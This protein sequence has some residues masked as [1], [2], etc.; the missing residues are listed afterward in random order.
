M[1]QNGRA[2]SASDYGY[3]FEVAGDNFSID[4]HFP[5]YMASETSIEEELYTWTTP[6][7][8]GYNDYVEFTTRNFLVDATQIAVDRG[9]AKVLYNGES[10]YIQLILYSQDGNTYVIDY[11]GTI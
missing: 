10:Y 11:N 8:W 6:S 5:Y 9:Q 4:V 2:E 1:Q 3:K 7:F